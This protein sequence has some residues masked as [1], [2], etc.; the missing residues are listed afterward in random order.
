MRFDVRC[1]CSYGQ[2]PSRNMSGSSRTDVLQHQST[3]FTGEAHIDDRAS[4]VVSFVK[5]EAAP[6]PW[7]GLVDTGSVVSFLTFSAF[8]R[9][10]VHTGAALR[11]YRIDLCAAK[12]K[13]IRTFGMVE[14]VRFQ[15]GGYEL[16]TNFVVVDDLM[17]VEDFLMSRKFFRTYQNLVDLATM[18]IMVRAP[19]NPVWHH[20][21]TQVGDSDTAIPVTI[22]QEVVLQPFERM[23]ARATVVTKNLEPPIFQTVALNAFLSDTSLHNVVFLKNSVAT[24]AETGSL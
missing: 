20:A 8:K 15:L 4:L 2:V 10:A 3:R 17:G 23:V 14:R 19:L 9:I 1:L 21:H 11:P 6:I 24:V 16:Q 12:G 13:T 18:R 7:R 5:P 22:A